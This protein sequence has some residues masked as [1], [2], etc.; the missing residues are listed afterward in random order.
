M[1]N[2]PSLPQIIKTENPSFVRQTDCHALLNVDKGAL[3]RSRAQRTKSKEQDNLKY[4]MQAM[5]NE[6]IELK[7]L[8]Q[9]LLQHHGIK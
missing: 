1:T 7:N 4:R 3:L 9:Q 8:V 5:Q 6:I 2:N